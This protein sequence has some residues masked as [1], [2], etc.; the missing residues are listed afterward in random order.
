MKTKRT[1]LV[2]K[3]A[4][5]PRVLVVI[6]THAN[7]REDVVE[8]IRSLKKGTYKNFFVVVVD[9]ANTDNTF[10][11]L[12]K[13]FPEVKIIRNKVNSGA[14]GGR[15][16]GI[17]LL[18]VKDDFILFLDS[19]IV[20]DKN[21]VSELVKAIND[22]EEFG[23]ATAK[24]L[25]YNNRKV[26]QYAG[27]RVGLITSINYSNTGPDDGRFDRPQT[28]EGA[29]GAVLIKREVIKKVGLFDDSFYPVYYEDADYS[30]RI[31]KAG[32][33]ILYV[34]SSRFF[35]KAVFLTTR[36]WLD[37]A[38]LTAR[39]KLIFMRKHSQNFSFFLLIYPIFPLFYLMTSMRYGRF[40]AL[41]N[42]IKG[43]RDG[44]SYDVKA[45]QARW[46]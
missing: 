4:N 34:P 5:Q 6:P 23:A 25:L 1:I 27:S 10:E 41:V 17:K 18:S 24:I 11:Y 22:D 20:A 38:Y 30:Y 35:H 9:Q 19:D 36:V 16:Q 37:N 32:Y 42:F 12:K 46:A 45:T 44:L 14:T 15:N 3:K 28:T 33:K 7:R 13:H 2:R 40:D 21:A 31:G 26:V 29:G 8:N 39:N 43:I